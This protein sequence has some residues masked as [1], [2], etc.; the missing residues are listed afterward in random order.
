MRKPILIFDFNKTSDI[1]DWKIV[2]DVV[3]GGRSNGKFYLNESGNGIFEG[4]VSLENNGGFSSLHYTF[5]KKNI[6]DYKKVKIHLKGDGKRYQFRVKS[7][8]SDRHSYV[9]YFRASG[10]WE[11]IT[12]DLSD[13]I[14]TFR[15][16]RITELPNYEAK[17]MVE[18]AFLIGNKKEQNFKLEIDKIE[19]VK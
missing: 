5:E 8:K 12:L 4:E 9:S 15:G 7:N 13:M 2:D 10:E 11:T 14:P 6:A 19:L 1:S 3:M 17:K 16:R 18:I